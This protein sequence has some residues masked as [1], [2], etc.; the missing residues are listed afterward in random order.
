MK[1]INKIIFLSLI[2]SSPF[3]FTNYH[4]QTRLLIKIPTRQRPDQIFKILDNYYQKL[5]GKY[6]Y[7]F[8][9]SCD[10]DDLSMNNPEIRQ[11]LDRYPNLRYR[12]GNNKSKIEAYNANIDEFKDWFDIL[13]VTSDD[14]EP[15]LDNYDEIIVQKMLE[16]FPNFSGVLSFADGFTKESINTYP[17]LGRE[18]YSQFGYVYYPGY[19]S[20]F[21]DNELRDVARMLKKEVRFEN[22]ILFKHLLIRDS[23]YAR[24]DT[25]WDRDK[26]L[27][28]Q[29]KNNQFSIFS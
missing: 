21:C 14:M 18:F 27:Y 29:R 24:N 1:L 6:S 11:K 12:F 8:L 19:I 3:N 15:Q 5:S 25:T 4:N 7:L 2:L 16:H 9:L 28:Y 10:T 20:V 17:I 22:I 26:R 13:I 23:L